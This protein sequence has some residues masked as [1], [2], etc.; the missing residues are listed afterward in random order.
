[1]G[2]CCFT[3]AKRQLLWWYWL[4]LLSVVGIPMFLAA[5]YVQR[6]ARRGLVE[7]RDV[8]RAAMIFWL[9]TALSGVLCFAGAW[10]LVQMSGYLYVRAAELILLIGGF[11]FWLLVAI[12]T[13]KLVEKSKRWYVR[14]AVLSGC[15]LAVL[16]F[17]GALEHARVY[18]APDWYIVGMLPVTL[19][20]FAVCMLPAHCW[21]R[22]VASPD[23][24]RAWMFLLALAAGTASFWVVSQFGPV[25][26]LAFYNQIMAVRGG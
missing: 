11:V 5:L 22:F 16:L 15:F 7:K 20:K 23:T 18:R 25:A 9:G 24:K 1:M 17:V 26:H 14:L 12:W 4:L 6:V 21:C 8:R 13:A 19:M 10:Y 3:P 2:G